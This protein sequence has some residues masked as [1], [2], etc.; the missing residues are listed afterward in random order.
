MF[1]LDILCSFNIIDFSKF[2][3]ILEH[4]PCNNNSISNQVFEDDELLIC[5]KN[6]VKQYK[7]KKYIVSLSGGVDS[8]VVATILCYLGY[9]VVGIHINYNNRKETKDEQKFMEV[10][11]KYNGIKLYVK[12]INDVTRGSIKRS[13]YESYTRKI[14]F[15]LYKEVLV[16]ES[17]DEILLGHHKDDI[18]ENI[19]ANVCRGRNILDLAVIKEINIVNNVR[20]VRPMINFYKETI[21]NF[22][23]KNSV[24]YFKDTTPDWSVRGKY[25]NKV[26]DNL[27]DTFGKNMKE[28]LIGLAKQSDEWNMLIMKQLIEP[29]LESVKYNYNGD[30]D[31]VYFNVEN[32]F[33]Y[34][35]CFWNS[36]FAKLFY[37]Y[38][39]NSPSKKGIRT[40]MNSI[41]G[42]GK[43][44]ISNSCI[45]KVTNYNVLI[46]FKT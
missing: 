35:L 16:A 21:Y 37:R 34:P 10:W 18:V 20:M 28:N 9:Q 42:I 22:A 23:H 17:S 8:M 6:Y 32:Y 29:F 2:E 40:F 25:R 26:H 13:D 15:D 46:S 5:F 43:V 27:E 3:R 45:C 41:P 24:P 31:N 1:L 36:V 33:K 30:S 4:I 14:R 19:V 44:S 7:K 38:G 39:K 12:S 11:C